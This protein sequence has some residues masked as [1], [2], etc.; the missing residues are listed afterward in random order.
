MKLQQDNNE[1]WS[2]MPDPRDKESNTLRASPSAAST[3]TAAAA[4]A[5]SFAGGPG[6][7]RAQGNPPY[8]YIIIQGF[9]RRLAPQLLLLQ[10]IRRVLR[11]PTLLLTLL[12]QS[13]IQAL[14]FLRSRERFQGINHPGN[15]L[16]TT[17]V[18]M[19]GDLRPSQVSD[20]PFLPA[21]MVDTQ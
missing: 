10:T 19:H 16:A 11:R 18:A 12:F 9:S 17:N 8:I 4:H 20:F 13:G 2:Q 6:S 21:L 15:E 14:A 7:G 1:L 5:S 3:Q